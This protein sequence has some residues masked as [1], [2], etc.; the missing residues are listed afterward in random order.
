M[1]AT[2]STKAPQGIRRW[3]TE[4]Q[5]IRGCQPCTCMTW[6]Y[7]S[8][9]SMLPNRWQEKKTVNCTHFSL[10]SS[11]LLILDKKLFLLHNGNYEQSEQRSEEWIQPPHF[12]LT[13][14]DDRCKKNNQKSES[15]TADKKWQKLWTL[16]K[17][18]LGWWSRTVISCRNAVTA[19]LLF[20]I[21]TCASKPTHRY[22]T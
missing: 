20:C 19:V 22:H 3:P 8:V 4:F 1:I 5:P 17:T 16:G 9:K 21:L 10:I 12:G 15:R 13:S 11:E 18:A 14:N 7:K 6:L 2:C